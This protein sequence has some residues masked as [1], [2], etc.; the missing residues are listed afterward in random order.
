M[1]V[2]KKN[3]EICGE[4]TVPIHGQQNIALTSTLNVV[5]R[6]GY[7]SVHTAGGMSDRH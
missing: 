1:A 3:L 4:F 7:L 2:F 5:L 6:A